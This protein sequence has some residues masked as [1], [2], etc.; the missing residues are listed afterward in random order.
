MKCKEIAFIAPGQAR[1]V[2][3]EL[4]DAPEKGLVQLKT[5]YTLI[6]PGTEFACLKG[7][8]G[9][10]MQFPIT[11]GYS[12]VAR[13]VKTGPEV[14]ELA[15]GDRC[16]CYH[17]AHRS[18]QNM[19][20][21]DVVRIEEDALPSQ[22][23]VFCVVGTMGFQGVRR[24]RPEFGES[25]LV[26]GLGLLGQFA[27]QTAHLC[28]CFPVI[29]LDFNADR[30]EKALSTGAD[31]CFSPDAPELAEKIR[32]LT[33]GGADMVIEVTGNPQAV[34][35]GLT[36]CAPFARVALVGCSRTPTENIDFYNLVH[37][38]GISIIGAHNMARPK[39]DRRPGVWTQPEDMLLLLRSM[40]LGRLKA[41]HL[42]TGIAD[43]AECEG[44]YDRLYKRD[45]SVF[46][47]LFDW[48]NYP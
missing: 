40:A 11:L 33:H 17:S 22:E 9:R 12:A 41:K 3:R 25:A 39:F 15:E 35:Q 31:A 42:I 44:I 4:P 27:V 30:R 18:W 13:V 23:A 7:A 45:P 48:R 38:P 10:P 37:R 5:E 29:G 16:L 20:A 32:E 34:V 24:C 14:T 47:Q 1:L 21:R 36:L 8:N 28:G 19:P 46:G 26:M 6:S 2:D 43:P